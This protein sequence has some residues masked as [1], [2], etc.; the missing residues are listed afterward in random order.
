VMPPPTVVSNCCSWSK[1]SHKALKNK[2]Q[3]TS[4]IGYDQSE[5]KWF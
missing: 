4:K 2:T 1:I 5:N 3:E